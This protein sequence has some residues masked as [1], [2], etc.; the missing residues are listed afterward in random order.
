MKI[1]KWHKHMRTWDAAAVVLW[2]G[3]VTCSASPAGETL[4]T[5]CNTETKEFIQVTSPGHRPPH[6][7][8]HNHSAEK[9]GQTP[10]GWPLSSLLLHCPGLSPHVREWALTIMVGLPT[11]IKE[12]PHRHVCRPAWFSNRQGSLPTWFVVVSW[13][14]LKLITIRFRTHILTWGHCGVRQWWKHCRLG[15]LAQV[16]ARCRLIVSLFAFQPRGDRP[17]SP[18]YYMLRMH[19][20]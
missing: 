5:A 13:W 3:N 8:S 18:H 16:T 9:R 20:K 7:G 10:V 12:I 15:L 17:Y 19:P 2:I 4:P 14:L 6:E 11:S 1:D